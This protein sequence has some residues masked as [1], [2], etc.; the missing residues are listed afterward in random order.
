MN[1]ITILCSLLIL[2]FISCGERVE[3]KTEVPAPEPKEINGI[4]KEKELVG[5]FR[6][7]PETFAANYNLGIFYYNLGVEQ[8]KE[9]DSIK[10]QEI[11][12]D[13]NLMDIPLEV[14]YYNLDISDLEGKTFALFNRAKVY[15]SKAKEIDSTNGDVIH[16]LKGC[17]F[18]VGVDF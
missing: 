4:D 5:N 11:V 3:P 7:A 14:L 18:L 16:A 15:L 1:K 10:Y 2:V 17:D 6:S 13:S 9:V 12:N 8:I